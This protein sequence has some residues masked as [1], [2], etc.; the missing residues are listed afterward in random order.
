[1]I[2]LIATILAIL[3]LAVA[4]PLTWYV[5]FRLWRLSR[6]APKI[7]VLRERAIAMLALALTVTVFALVFLNNEQKAPLLDLATTRVLT[8]GSLFVLSVVP[9]FYWWFLYRKAD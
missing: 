1:V 8:R 6:L 5:A 9:A 3:T 7:A 4:L 2:A